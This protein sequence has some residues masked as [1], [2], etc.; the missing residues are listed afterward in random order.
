[1]VEENLLKRLRKY[2]AFLEEEINEHKS[3]EKYEIM[4]G[5][6]NQRFAIEAHEED[7]D[8]LYEFFPELNLSDEK[9][10]NGK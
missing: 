7:K 3:S 10:E 1:M 6:T 2:L 9:E 5:S 4:L 8:K